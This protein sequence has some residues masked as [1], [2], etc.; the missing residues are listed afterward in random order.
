MAKNKKV[1]YWDASVFIAWM[2]DEVR[3]NPQEMGGVYETAAAVERGEILLVCG[4]IINEDMIET[5]MSH[6]AREKYYGLFPRRKSQLLPDDPRVKR[7]T[8]EIR[9]FYA[10]RDEPVPKLPDAA[11][12]AYAIHYQVDEFHTFDRKLL[13]LDGVVAGYPLCICKP[14]ASQLLIPFA[15][16][17]SQ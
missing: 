11:H 9:E 6:E 5:T 8:R 3:E 17:T 4:E 15:V 16:P 12:L 2:K 10:L 1:V 14:E 7:L 13:A